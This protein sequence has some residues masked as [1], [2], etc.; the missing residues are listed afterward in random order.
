MTL[1]VSFSPLHAALLATFTAFAV[2]AHAADLEIK[3]PPGGKV[4]IKDSTGA[5]TPL[6]IDGAGPVTVPGLPASTVVSAGVVCFDANG[7]LAK[8]APIIGAQGPVGP[9]GAT[10]AMGAAGA[11][12]I[13]GPTGSVGVTGLAGAT[14][15]AGPTGPIG[16]TGLTG[17]TGAVGQVGITGAV[18]ATGIAGPTGSM[19]TT[20]LTGATG[21]VGQ[22]GGTGAA[23]ST[24][25]AGPTGPIGT[26]GLTGATGAVG[27]VGITGAVGATGIAGAAGPMGTTGA[28]G[29]TGATGPTPNISLTTYSNSALSYACQ[30]PSIT[31]TCATGVVVSGGCDG[32]S[33]A[34]VSIL[35][36]KR[37]G[38]N[39]WQCVFVNGCNSYYSSVTNIAY[40]YCM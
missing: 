28:T 6:I 18:G 29:A 26:T 1:K 7:T 31:A 32:S 37:I 12:G 40:A 34:Y 16:T 4:L 25:I 3:A 9:A 8:C 21:A 19:G 10:G 33:N 13:A 39:E 23:G 36:S 24:G 38:T 30:A 15:I 11:I 20:G 14:G 27:Q 35:S 22:V 17:A 2:S 5:T